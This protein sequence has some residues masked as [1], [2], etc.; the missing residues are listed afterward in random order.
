MS[1][2]R[3]IPRPTDN[4]AAFWA[5][6]AEGRFQLQRC[7]RCDEMI[8]YPRVNCPA[9]GATDLATTDASGRGTVFTYTIA[10]RPTHPAFA[11][12]GPYVIA[13]VELEEGPHVTTNIVECEP[14]DVAI[15]MPVEL[16][17]GDV[18]D[19]IALPF[20]RPSATEAAQPQERP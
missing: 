15:G 20:F 11:E 19:D 10:R 13:I 17:F 12:A 3:P 5:A 2:N 1:I 18:V 14:D 7:E 16:M 4:S 6:T 8:F 9:C